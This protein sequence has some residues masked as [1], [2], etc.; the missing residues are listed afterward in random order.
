MGVDEAEALGHAAAVAEMAGGQRLLDQ[1]AASER[2]RPVEDGTLGDMTGMI[3]R[4]DAVARLERRDA[5]GDRLG[6][7]AVGDQLALLAQASKGLERPAMVDDL[8]VIAVRM[9]QHD[10]DPVRVQ[11][12]EAALDT[13]AH[14]T[15]REVET[16]LAARRVEFLAD[17]GADHPALAL[18]GEQAAE[19]RLAVAIGRRRVDE[20]DAEIRRQRQQAGGLGV[21]RQAE[22]LGIFDRAVAAELDGAEPER[23]DLQAG[24]SERPQ[25][26]SNNL[27]HGASA[28]PGRAMTSP[29]ASRPSAKPVGSGKSAT[30]LSA[31][32]GAR[33][34][35]VGQATMNLPAEAA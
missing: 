16:A 33:A 29:M 5:A 19:A 22:R 23:A 32:T 6:R 34:S 10:I 24:R 31:S 7:D 30:I 4:H 20:I 3:G 13:H 11:P 21:A 28:K 14:M 1:Y 25:L 2:E 15:G 12:T 17:L 18:A 27:S 26:Q 8:V 9:H 35:L